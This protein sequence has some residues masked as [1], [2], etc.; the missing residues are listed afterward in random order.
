[1]L[2]GLKQTNKQKHDLIK[3]K[4]ESWRDLSHWGLLKGVEI[5]TGLN[6]RCGTRVEHLRSGFLT[7]VRGQESRAV[8]RGRER[9]QRASA[10]C[11]NLR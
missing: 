11:P 1:M 7:D 9:K 3:Q 5:S 6:R 8:P 4:L 2:P 10:L